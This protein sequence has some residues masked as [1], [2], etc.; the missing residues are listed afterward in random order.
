MA[1]TGRGGEI[2]LSFGYFYVVVKWGKER[3]SSDRVERDRKMYPALT[4]THLPVLVGAWTALVVL[5]Y[6]VVSM[7]LEALIWLVT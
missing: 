1:Q 2:R 4:S 3:R 7:S 6:Y 5:L